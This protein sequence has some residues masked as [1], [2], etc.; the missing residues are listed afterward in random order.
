[1][2][3]VVMDVNCIVDGQRFM[4]GFDQSGNPQ[5]IKECK[6]F[7]KGHPDKLIYCRPYWSP[8]Q[9][10]GG[11]QTLAQRIIAAARIKALAPER[12]T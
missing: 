8:P 1:M 2:V 7:P 5:W 6:V 9:K 4:V 3:S 12:K 10:L 11:P